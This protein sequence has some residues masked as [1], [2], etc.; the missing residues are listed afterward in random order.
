MTGYRHTALRRGLIIALT[1]WGLAS[2]AP[3]FVRVFSAYGTLGFEANNDGVVTSVRGAPLAGTPRVLVA[4]AAEATP[5]HRLLIAAALAYTAIQIEEFLKSS[6]IIQIVA[7]V[8]LVILLKITF[9]FIHERLNRACDWL[10]FRHLH[11]AERTVDQVAHELRKAESFDAI[12]LQLICVPSATLDLASAA[13]FRRTPSGHY[14][15][16]IDPV[17]WSGGRHANCPLGASELDALKK[18]GTALRL[19]E[20]ESTRPKA[21]D[22]V[23]PVIALPV[24]AGEELVAVTLYGS[25]TSGY[26]ITTDEQNILL[27]L[28]EAAG[29]AYEEVEVES[30]R[31]QIGELRDR[32]AQS[33][34][35]NAAPGESS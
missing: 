16:R 33:S 12:D 20:L 10:F 32:L 35:R 17:G 9:E 2:V 11:V 6:S 27:E 28:I 30:L 22:T 15:Q 19:H 5:T 18:S 13:V 29:N 31:R 23:E 21:P 4:R 7:Y 1:V 8:P 3:E 26:D 34:V 14:H 25:H 24:M